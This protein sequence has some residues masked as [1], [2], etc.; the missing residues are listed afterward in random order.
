MRRMAIIQYRSRSFCGCVR[1]CERRSIPT[2]DNGQPSD[3]RTHRAWS[4]VH[5]HRPE[6][7]GYQSVDLLNCLIEFEGKPCQV[8]TFEIAV[9]LPENGPGGIGDQVY[10]VA[11]IVAVTQAAHPAEK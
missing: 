8:H 5:R 11:F 7:R 10:L 6:H 4:G 3:S 9:L 2:S 1:D